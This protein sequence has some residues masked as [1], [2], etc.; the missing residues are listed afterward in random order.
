MQTQF[1]SMQSTSSV[2]LKHATHE[3]MKIAM[4]ASETGLAND[5]VK[6]KVGFSIPRES[7]VLGLLTKYWSQLTANLQSSQVIISEKRGW[8]IF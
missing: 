8:S 6:Y 4:Y 3:T 5:L 1:T 7:T 2:K